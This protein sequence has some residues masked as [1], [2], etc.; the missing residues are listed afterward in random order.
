[1]KQKVLILSKSI[2]ELDD[3][4]KE[5]IIDY[6][7]R[8]I[9]TQDPY[10]VENL[11]NGVILGKVDDVIGGCVCLFPIRMMLDGCDC[12]ALSGST[13]WVSKDYRKYELGFSIPEKMLELS[14]NIFF[15]GVSEKAQP[16]YK[17]FGF[18]LFKLERYVF[19]LNS[20]F[21]LSQKL[22]GFVEKVATSVVD[23]ALHTSYNLLKL[24][25]KFKYR[26][27][28][29][30]EKQLENIDFSGIQKIL[31]ADFHRYKEMHDNDWIR[32]VMN[33]KDEYSE[34]GQHFYEVYHK[35]ELV[36]FFINKIRFRELL[37]GK[38]KNVVF[39]TLLEWGSINEKILSNSDLCAMSFSKFGLNT[40]AIQIISDEQSFTS[41]IPNILKRRMRDFTYAVTLDERQF[42]A[43]KEK[44]NWR[45]RPAGGDISFE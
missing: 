12:F 2:N 27:F 29:I 44:E 20:H 8:Y 28:K 37:N 21:L 43:Y 18:S 26:H 42:P 10:K 7:C 39:G 35:G 25:Y 40:D 30:V 1:M 6:K 9:L 32:W 13:F 36:G 16:V 4:E 41:M 22:T 38:Y 19:I 24:Y 5:S 23:I 45:L 14:P 34:S 33:F 3:F 15:C 11:L 17:Y 31:D